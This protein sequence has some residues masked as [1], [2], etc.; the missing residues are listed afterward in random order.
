MYAFSRSLILV[1]SYFAIELNW[2]SGWI[3]WICWISRAGFSGLVNGNV[4][5]NPS[6]VKCGFL[7]SNLR[8]GSWFLVDISRAPPS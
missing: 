4:K 7:C 5:Y 8:D 2:K 3:F 1:V 6:S